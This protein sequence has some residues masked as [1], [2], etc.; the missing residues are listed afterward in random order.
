MAQCDMVGKGGGGF[1]GFL[2]RRGIHTGATEQ[3]VG[4][5]GAGWE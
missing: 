5:V 3:S 1:A 2:Q 4:V